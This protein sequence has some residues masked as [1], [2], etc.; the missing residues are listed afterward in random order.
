MTKAL[1]F[2][3]SNL[4]HMNNFDINYLLTHHM[5]FSPR[6]EPLLMFC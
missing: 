3:Q 1:D 4:L 2:F 5:A 6:Y